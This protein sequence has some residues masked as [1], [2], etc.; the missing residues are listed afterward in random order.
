MNR[1]PEA[2]PD[3]RTLA[4]RKRLG[5]NPQRLSAN[6]SFCGL[7]TLIGGRNIHSLMIREIIEAVGSIALGGIGV[8]KRRTEKEK[9]RDLIALCI[10][11]VVVVS[12]FAV[13]FWRL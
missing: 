7:I 1:K 12:V 11:G 5:C 3:F 6:F 8:T 10:F 2:V 9:K 4:Q 13:A